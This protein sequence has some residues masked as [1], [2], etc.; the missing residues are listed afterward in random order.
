MRSS[1]SRLSSRAL[2]VVLD[3]GLSLLELLAVAFNLVVG[4]TDLLVAELNFKGLELNFLTQGVIFAVVL[5]VVE[6]SLI[7][8]PRLPEPR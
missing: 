8:A 7:A 3:V 4:L 2:L 5:H 6:L 1:S